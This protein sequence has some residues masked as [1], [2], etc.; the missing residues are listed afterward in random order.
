MIKVIISDIF[1][2]KAQTLANTVN[3][4]GVMGKGIALG[5]KKNFPDMYKDYEELLAKHH[6]LIEA[7]GALLKK[8]NP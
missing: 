3:C 8:V 7:H 4:V 5:F 2:S 6:N 1:K